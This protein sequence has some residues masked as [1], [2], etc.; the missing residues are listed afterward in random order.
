MGGVGE[1]GTAAEK[2]E[3]T[4]VAEGGI[5]KERE[6]GAEGNTGEEGEE[7][8]KEKEIAKALGGEEEREP[9]ERLEEELLEKPTK[10]EEKSGMPEEETEKTEMENNVVSMEDVKKRKAQQIKE[11]LEKLKGPQGAVE[12]SDENG[13]G[14]KEAA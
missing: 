1:A 14:H 3:T 8:Q 10:K 6:S 4:A 12:E 2:T 9:I 13:E 5:E 7:Q 11:Q